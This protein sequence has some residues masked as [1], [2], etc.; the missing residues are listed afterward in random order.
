[1]T[2]EKLPDLDLKQMGDVQDPARPV[3][4]YDWTAPEPH[5]AA[6]HAHPRAHLIV[7]EAGAY[8]VDTDEGVWLV[9]EGLAVWVPPGVRH[10]IYSFGAVKAQILFVDASR[11][12][13]L[14]SRPGTV[15]PSRVM[16]AALTRII[17]NGNHY[18]PDSPESRLTEVMLDELR[19]MSFAG[20]PLPATTEPRVARVM[21]ALIAD[22]AAEIESE[23]LAELAQ[24]SP[25][26]LARLFKAETGMTLGRW[27]TNLR[28]Q[29]ALRRLAGGTSVTEVAFDLGYNSASAFT[30]MFRRNIGVPPAAYLDTIRN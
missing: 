25:S 14:P 4:S 13:D 22:P 29:E 9:P 1:M 28:L 2:I 23:A 6:A 17:A 12:A 27:R 5:R 18:A 7:V 24:T 30:Y 20:S 10:Q 3:L 21:Q 16:Q 15:K 19:G 11:T 8:W 26:T